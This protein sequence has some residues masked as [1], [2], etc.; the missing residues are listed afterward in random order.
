MQVEDPTCISACTSRPA[1]FHHAF[2]LAGCPIQATAA[3]SRRR[4]WETPALRLARQF[5]PFGECFRRG[6]ALELMISTR[7][8]RATASTG[9]AHSLRVRSTRG[10]P[11]QACRGNIGVL[12]CVVPV[13]VLRANQV[14]SERRSERVVTL[15]KLKD[16]VI[17]DPISIIPTFALRTLEPNPTFWAS[18]SN[19]ELY[20]TP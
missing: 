3:Y 18:A 12:P 6:Q 15:C 13:S 9:A 16:L 14:A 17:R 10:P 8:P 20:S 5:L 11:R 1:C 4:E 19:E 7:S 2:V